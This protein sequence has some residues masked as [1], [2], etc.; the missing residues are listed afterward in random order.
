[1]HDRITQHARPRPSTPVSAL[2]FA[3]L[4][5]AAVLAVA[6]PADALASTYV[7]NPKLTVLIAAGDGLVFDSFT[8]DRAVYH[9]DPCVLTPINSGN[10]VDLLGSPEDLPQ[11][12]CAIGIETGGAVSI[13]G[14]GTAGGTFRFD[15]AVGDLIQSLTTPEFMWSDGSSKAFILLVAST[16]WVTAA[17]L[18]LQ[19]GGSVVVDSNHPLYQDLADAIELDTHLYRDVDGDGLLSTAERIAGPLD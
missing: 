4:S 11:D 17:D 16:D 13:D 12:A 3:A 19:A 9:S 7:G 14:H 15:L 8:V 1:M 6:A 18:G 5:F 10:P 2:R